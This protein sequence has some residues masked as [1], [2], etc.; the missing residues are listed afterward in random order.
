MRA[1]QETEGAATAAPFALRALAA[2]TWLSGAISTALILVFFCVT[3]YS[4]FMR[5][6]LNR[7]LSWAD[8]LTG[9]GLVALVMFG[10]CEAYRRGDHIAI[11]LAVGRLRPRAARLQRIWADLGVLVLAGVL[12]ASAWES[13]DF[14]RDFGSYTSGRLEIQSWIPQVPLLV[15][16]VLLGLTALG[17]IA[18]HVAGPPAR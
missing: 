3:L 15:G 2:L 11:D 6:V 5:Y 9:W 18:A 1:S 4:V 10:A 12:G 17:R 7:P 8:E 14:A 16:A 13:I